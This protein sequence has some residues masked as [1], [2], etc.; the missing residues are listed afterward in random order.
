[1]RREGREESA[2]IGW[3][4]WACTSSRKSVDFTVMD[5]DSRT[6]KVVG[7]PYWGKLDVR[8]DEGAEGIALHVGIYPDA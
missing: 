6:G 3:P 2:A 5:T 8:F 7:K 4:R 1:M